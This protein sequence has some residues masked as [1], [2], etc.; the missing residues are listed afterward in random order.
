MVRRWRWLVVLLSAAVL[1]ALPTVSG[2]LHPQLAGPMPAALLLERIDGTATTPYS[3][4]ASATGGLALPPSGQWESV[5]RMLRGT[6]RMRVWFR[7]AR[8]WRVDSVTA[9]GEV[10]QH[11]T[12]V[13][14]WTWDYE[15]NRA[16]LETGG[17]GE[18]PAVR[19]PAAADLLP[20]AL[21]HRLLS[22][23]RPSEVSSLASRWVAGREAQGL[24]LRPSDPR[25]TIGRVDV[26]ADRASGIPLQ[27]EV[28]AAAGGVGAP[29]M[30]ADFTDFSTRTPTARETAFAP[31]A[32]V[33]VSGRSR[34]DLVAMVSRFADASGPV[35]LAGLPRNLAVAG[36]SGVPVYGRG[37]TELVAV[38]LWPE[39]AVG[40]RRELSR[41]PGT[42]STDGGLALSV[43]PVG[44]LLTAPDEDA[45]AWL[46]TG[47]VTPAT[48]ATA[49][50]ELRRA[51]R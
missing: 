45:D 10:G 20:P 11:R 29:V 36:S 5:V 44:L 25:S 18:D 8:D 39:Q 22:G 19:L 51:G 46:L 27:V 33:R 50:E 41:A 1:V 43:G 49:A 6:T 2:L 30:V 13:G 14:L 28:V 17:P 7:S 4:Y 3:G 16:T 38:P 9:T 37:V 31:A 47:T 40:L 21:A 23:A 34:P 15:H 42:T 48:M 24:R 26:W 12:A 35:V 32:A